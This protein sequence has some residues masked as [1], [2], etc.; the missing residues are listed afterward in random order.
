MKRQAVLNVDL[1]YLL[2]EP[3]YHDIADEIPLIVFLHGRGERGTDLSLVNK[4]GVPKYLDSGQELPALVYAPQCPE[5]VE[6]WVTILGKVISKIDE[7][8]AHYRIRETHLTGFS[9]GGHGTHY[10]AVQHPDRFASV[11]PVATYMYP[12]DDVTNE[13]CI[14][15]DAPIWIFH[16]A[17][18]WVPVAHSDK[19]VA[20]LRAC[21]AQDLTYTRLSDEGHTETADFAYLNKDLYA[22]MLK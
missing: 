13:V 14:L 22:W 11:S 12:Q 10:L 18:D 19:V 1:P 7:L 2:Y 8:Q 15:K 21:D 3:D 6:N 17:S 4:W 16:S 9:M 5:S 20:T